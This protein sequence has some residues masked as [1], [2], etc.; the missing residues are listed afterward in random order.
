MLE[1][2]NYTHFALPPPP[3]AQSYQGLV[4]KNKD[5]IGVGEEGAG[6]SE[7]CN[8]RMNRTGMQNV[9][10]LLLEIIYV[11]SSR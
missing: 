11:I 8:G 5:L 3:P 1:A 6:E 9:A 4:L 2:Q 7:G 10:L